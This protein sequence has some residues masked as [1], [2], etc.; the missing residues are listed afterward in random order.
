MSLKAI[1]YTLMAT[2]TFVFFLG[3]AVAFYQPS[4]PFTM[5]WWLMVGGWCIA[6]V[7]IGLHAY[8]VIKL[9]KGRQ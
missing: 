7:G 6:M 5:S 8:R 3:I 9:L 2:G 1:S 4:S